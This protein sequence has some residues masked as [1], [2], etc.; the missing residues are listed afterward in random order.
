MNA[1][2]HDASD[3]GHG[4]V[5]SGVRAK[6]RDHSTHTLWI[7]IAGI[8]FAVIVGWIL[9]ASTDLF[10][11]DQPVAIEEAPNPQSPPQ[12]PGANPP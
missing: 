3:T 12:V 7:L 11:A 1:N 2:R 6:Q 4:Q 8:V 9:L 5:K 10:T